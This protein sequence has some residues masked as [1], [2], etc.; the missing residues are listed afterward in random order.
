MVAA[1]EVVDPGI[2][3]TIQDLPG[4]VGSAHRGFSPAGPADPFSLRA[5]NLLVGND[6]QA[7]A[8]E[9]PLVRI[10]LAVLCEG[11]L[12]VTGAA[13]V[14]LTINGSPRPAW[15]GVRVRPGQEIQLAMSGAPGFRAYLA[16]SGGFAVR[17]LLDSGSTYLLAGVGGLAGRALVA[18]D[19]LQVNAGQS[20]ALRMPVAL[21]PVFARDW[22]VEV[23]KGPHADPEYLTPTDWKLFTAEPWRVDLNSNRMATRLRGP[24]F[25]WARADGGIAGDHPSNILETPYPVGGVNVSGDEP[26]VLGPEGQTCG[27]FVIIGVV[28]RAARWRIGQCRPGRDTVTFR[29]VSV[30]QAV[31]MAQRQRAALDPA[32][33]DRL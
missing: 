28:P 16:F 4:R 23:V 9:I 22:E 10:T 1:L 8:L 20:R 11:V 17:E 33:W 26:V 25:E 6:P 12:A 27:G 7:P 2:Q 18:G 31:E 19:I 5:A 21:R 29:E 24:R 13:G 30:A 3:T 15:E 32:R 14:E